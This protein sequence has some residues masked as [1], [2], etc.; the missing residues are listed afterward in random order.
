MKHPKQKLKYV[1]YAR[2]S[3]ESE[4]RQV[5]SI[6]DQLDRLKVLAKD[7]NFKIV[8]IYKESHSA[9]QPNTRPLFKEMLTFINDGKADGILCWHIN[10]LAR[11]PLDS[12]QI[13]WMLQNE[14]LKSVQTI[15]KEYR[16]EDNILM[17]SVESGMANQFIIDLKKNTKRGLES[18][19]QKGWCPY[20]APAGYMNDVINKTILKDADRFKLIQNMWELIITSAYSPFQ[21]LKILNREWG[22]I[23]RKTKRA[24]GKPMGQAEFYRIL[25]N[26]FYYG[27]FSYNDELYKGKHEPMISLEQYESVQQILGNKLKRKERKNNFAFTGIITCGNCGCQIT[28]EEKTK[29][30]KSENIH[31]TYTYYRCTHR[32]P[33][34]FCDE[35]AVTLPELEEQIINEIEKFA[36]HSDFKDWALGIIKNMNQKEIDDRKHQYKMLEKKYQSLQKQLDNLTKMRIKEL[37]T[38]D[39]FIV[40]KKEITNEITRIR[41]KLDTNKDRGQ[42][43]IETIDKAFNF[44]IHAR[45]TFIDGDIKTKRDIMSALGQNYTLKDKKLTIKPM[46]WLIPL[47]QEKRNINKHFST[48]ELNKT[49]INTNKNTSLEKEMS[50]WGPIWELN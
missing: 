44:A 23:S 2:K 37:L 24:G 39:E 50:L 29:Y 21:V 3:S 38:D 48:L 8:K 1:L 41:E 26:P 30:I 28:A 17:F 49:L 16:P 33:D 15:D 40:Q 43:W 4:D 13:S 45:Q 34:I 7:R 31:R 35:T 47:Y 11:N 46:E 12:G 32:K 42:S 27:Y 25:N 6:K 9:K 20:R 36:I 22:Y 18:K 5:Q 10:R 14:V 19:V